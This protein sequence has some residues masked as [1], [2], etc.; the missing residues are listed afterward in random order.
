MNEINEITPLNIIPARA[1]LDSRH[2]RT[3]DRL[4]T[5]TEEP[6]NLVDRMYE[7]A[8]KQEK[9]EKREQVLTA[10]KDLDLPGKLWVFKE[11]K[12]DIK[13]M[14][15]DTKGKSR[16]VNEEFEMETPKKSNAKEVT[17]KLVTPGKVKK[18]VDVMEK[19]TQAGKAA[20]Q[21]K[22]SII[23]VKKARKGHFGQC[24]CS[25]CYGKVFQLYN[26]LV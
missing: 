11:L 1:S 7:E 12:Q 17:I 13:K 9:R 16:E 18:E 3:S 21:K 6:V 22:N 8:A 23:E 10:A 25:R 4:H 19:M 5:I 26:S 20:A 15:M 24:S 14:V 2:S